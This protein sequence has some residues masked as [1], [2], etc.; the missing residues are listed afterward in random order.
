MTAILLTPDHFPISVRHYYLHPFTPTLLPGATLRDRYEAMRGK[1][2]RWR[3][4]FFRVGARQRLNGW[5]Q[6]EI[7]EDRLEKLRRH[8]KL[9]QQTLANDDVQAFVV[10]RLFHPRFGKQIARRILTDSNIISDKG[11]DRKANGT[12]FLVYHWLCRYDV[13][14]GHTVVLHVSLADLAHV[15][16]IGTEAVK[17][18]LKALEVN[19]LIQI[20]EWGGPGNRT[21][22]WRNPY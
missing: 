17:D 6:D 4:S 5:S 1:E 13:V 3:D 8:R 20:R 16:G 14:A 11:L 18:A 12:A 15:C 19:K 22:L 21:T 2:F 7:L 9:S 10:E